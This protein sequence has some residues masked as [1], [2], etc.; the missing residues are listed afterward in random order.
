[1]KYLAVAILSMVYSITLSQSFPYTFQTWDAKNGLSSN[2]CNAIAQDDNGYLYVGTNNGLFVFNGNDFMP[3]AFHANYSPIAEGR[4]E[5]IVTDK[6]NRV[7]FASFEYGLGLIDPG[8]ENK[9]LQYFN[10]VS[11]IAPLQD[12]KVSKLCFD[13]K[14]YLW[15]GTRGYGL[16]KFDTS[17]KKFEAVAIEN[18]TSI[19]R[20]HIRALQ[21]FRPDTLFVG[22]V[23]GLSIVNPLNGDVSH[24]TMTSAETNVLIRPTVRKILHKNSDSF[25]LATDRGT[26]MLKLSSQKLSSIYT[27]SSDNIDFKL[28]NSNDI[29]Q[30]S[31]EELWI[32]TENY[33]VMFYNTRTHKFNYSYRLN[34]FNAGIQKGAVNRFYKDAGGNIW[35]A[36]QNGLSLFQNKNNVF[37]SYSYS[38]KYLFASSLIADGQKLISCKSFSIVTI[39]MVT[40][41]INTHSLSTIK[42]KTL[43]HCYAIN[44]TPADYLFFVN[45]S[46]FIVNKKNLQARLLPLNKEKLSSSYFA[47]FRIFKCIPD[48]VNGVKQYLLL[49]KTLNGFKLLNYNPDNGNLEPYIFKNAPEEYECTNIVKSAS[50]KYWISTKRDGILYVDDASLVMQYAA[51]VSDTTKRIP[52]GE[53]KDFVFTDRNNLWSLI[54]NTGLVHISVNSTKKPCYEIYSEQAGLMDARLF[55]VLNDNNGNLWITGRSGVT[56]FNVEQKEFFNYSALNG[57]GNIIF[58]GEE[59]SDIVKANDFIGLSDRSSIITWFKSNKQ[60][61]NLKANLMIKTIRLNDSSINLSA[62]KRKL[63]LQPGQND[64]SFQYDIIDFDKTSH[65]GILYKLDHFD[66]EW[67]YTD[68]NEEKQYMNLPPGDYTFR[69]KL[70]FAN[71]RYSP[72]KSIQFF[73]ATYW[74]KTWWFKCIALLVCAWL[75]YLIIRG[76]ISRKL[77]QH[78]KELE[79]HQAVA[80]ERA[81]IST[82]LHDDLGS[83]LSTIRILSQSDHGYSTLEKISGHSKELLQKMTEI[84]WA[85]NIDND[86]LDQ[87]ISYIRHQSVTL[88]DG[89]SLRYSFDIPE[90]IPPIKVSG[91]N[92]R[93]IQLMVKEAVHNIIKH[94]EASQVHFCIS[95]KDR[96]IIT[97]ADNGKGITQYDMMKTESNG[98]RNMQKHIDAIQGNMQIKNGIGLSLIF[99][100][101]LHRL[102]HESAI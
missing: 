65:Y 3:A 67:H 10:P 61:H 68:K 70:Q 42:R 26:F 72:E 35:I 54:K 27:N 15:V 44:Y 85:L 19:Y 37:N 83:G 86:T 5:D 84:V 78:K 49:A 18:T 77:Y 93:H 79:L 41:D 73:I 2:F 43:G 6:Y 11:D 12:T 31:E 76:Y 16:F 46:F 75:I 59:R 91:A 69:M 57:L 92:R 4:I 48:T 56:C 58:Y 81:R 9:H 38:D 80:V 23:N 45:D 95:I 50:G 53:I 89:A 87:L 8:D 62:L 28:I 32:A 63:Q 100:I 14:G 96:L 47:H 51:K 1:M 74:Y 60:K 29:I 20:K 102:S 52:A 34:E 39:N 36:Q 25:L 33:G 94:A 66:K 17:T 101:P 97:I 82:E 71:G 88:L 64:I 24:L 22:L 30:L 99:S 90:T 21:L 40:G 55:N 13:S 7:W 98:M